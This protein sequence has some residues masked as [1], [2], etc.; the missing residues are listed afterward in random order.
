VNANGHALYAVSAIG[1]DRPGIVAAVSGVLLEVEA[2]IED[3][4]MS[5][6]RGHFA[7]MLIVSVPE[8]VAGDEL[9]AKLQGVRADL[10]LEAVAVTE[11]DELGPA[12]QPS[13]V[14][15]VYGADH[16]G[17]VHS[18][19]KALAENE[20]NISDVQTKLTGG[21][22]PVYVML[23]EI[24]VSGDVEPLRSS[25]DAVAEEA[26]L[27]LSLRELETEAL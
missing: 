3:S 1:R 4:Q 13:H 10:D 6:L 7:M 17:I 21:E 12:G 27:D 11:V 16:P 24:A 8:G 26:G 15:S 22:S 20:A 2:N 19:S 14:L 25:L 5:I 9:A 23:I 18:V